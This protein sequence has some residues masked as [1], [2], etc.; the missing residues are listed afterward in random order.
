MLLS[1]W[2]TFI[3]II[4]PIVLLPLLTTIAT[5]ESRCAYVVLIMAIFWATEP[6]P[7]PITALLPVILLP[8]L[9]LSTTEEACTP[10]LKSSN[11]LFLGCLALALAVERSNLHKRIALKVLLKVGTQ[12]EW[13][14]LGFML[15]TMMLSMWIV[16]TATVAMM[17]PIADEILSHLFA[18]NNTVEDNN[19][20][21]IQNYDKDNNKPTILTTVVTIDEDFD[22]IKRNKLSKLLYL[23]I[24]YSATMGSVSTLT[25]NG[26][27]IVMKHLLEELYGNRDPVDYAS[28]FIYASPVSIIITLICWLSYKL[29]FLRNISVP[30]EK[31]QALKNILSKKYEKLGSI[32]FHEF[33]VLAVFVVMILLYFFHDPQ[34]MTGWSKLLSI[35][36]IKPKPA[37]GAI[38]CTL[39]LFVIP[40]N[41][42]GP[43]PSTA[44]LDWKTVQTKLEWGVII[45]RGGGFSIADAVTSSGLSRLVGQQL[46]LVASLPTSAVTAL[47]AIIASFLIEVMRTSATATILIPVAAQLSEDLGINPLI[48]IITLAMSCAYAYLLPVGTTANTIVYYHAK[49]NISD[50][51]V[52]G[53][54]AK[55]ISIAMMLLNIYLLGYPIFNLHDSSPNWLH[56]N[57]TI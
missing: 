42:F 9:G 56:E 16:S 31:R 41:P 57:Y 53:L 5:S 34:F 43:T 37:G 54:I 33:A 20:K 22:R 51:I 18:N 10:F 6:I 44:L 46:T 19:K 15:T 27:N 1:R 12:F 48:L 2:R 8:L 30:K 52:P 29:L 11:M 14:L 7:L 39:L 47:L 21:L 25:A 4:T 28:W 50:M 17:L 23:S 32:T 13:L 26:P 49:L 36:N 45:L 38:F 40:S 24:A 35:N 55:I 3:L